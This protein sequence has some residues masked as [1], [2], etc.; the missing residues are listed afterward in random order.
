MSGALLLAVDVGTLSARAG[1]FDAAGAL[2]ATAAAP[3]TLRRPREGFAVYRMAEI[4]AATE[5]AIQGALRAAPAEAPRIAG[6]AFD[7]TRRGSSATQES[8]RE[9]MAM[10][11][12]PSAGI[13]PGWRSRAAGSGQAGW[14]WRQGRS[15]MW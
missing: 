14:R 12:S 13:Q 4:W 7:A 8:N 6:L 15:S 1:L 10:R 11:T 3:F 2:L 5:T 9:V